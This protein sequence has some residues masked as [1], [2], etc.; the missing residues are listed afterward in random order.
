M[1]RAFRATRIAPTPSGFLHEGNAYA[2]VLAAALAK[3][4]GAS[5]LLRIDDLDN[6]RKRPEYVAD[7]FDTLQWLGIAWN[8]GPKNSAE[9]DS[10]WTQHNRLH[11]YEAALQALR[12]QGL[13][14]ACMC[15]RSDLARLKSPMDNEHTC[16]LGR[17][18]LDTKDVA[19]RIRIPPQVELSYNKFGLGE[20]QL[21]ER[22]M[23]HDPVVRRRDGIPAYHIASVCDD[24]HF[25]IDLI[26][27]GEDLRSSTAVQL[28]LAGQLGFD[29]FRTATFYHH[30]LLLGP[31]G[32]KWSKS[33]GA[34]AIKQ[35]SEKKEASTA[36]YRKLAS[37]HGL[38][39]E[40]FDLSTFAQRLAEKLG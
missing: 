15:S 22:D 5:I 17:L 32:E 37:F 30:P 34:E 23:P 3:I 20:T 16:R 28:W 4:Y 36:L 31:N 14:Y 19:W 8:Q 10:E 21:S 9:L 6:D 27:R 18:S 29:G 39:S 40:V 7:V 24:H 13:L 38:S 1:N 2:F 26:V 35:F 12:N 33:A 11:L 25:G